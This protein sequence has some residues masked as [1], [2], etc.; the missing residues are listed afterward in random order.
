MESATN[1]KTLIDQFELMAR[2]NAVSSAPGSQSVS[3]FKKTTQLKADNLLVK[4][5][6][7]HMITNYSRTP[8]KP[9]QMIQ[10]AE[11][12]VEPVEDL[13]REK[14]EVLCNTSRKASFYKRLTVHTS[15]KYD[16]TALD[17]YDSTFC[18]KVPRSPSYSTASTC[19]LDSLLSPQDSILHELLQKPGETNTEV[20][21]R[22]RRPARDENLQ[23]TTTSKWIPA[24]S[25]RRSLLVRKPPF[26]TKKE[27][28]IPVPKSTSLSSKSTRSAVV[29]SRPVKSLS[30]ISSSPR[31]M[32]YASSPRY[33][34]TKAWNIE[35]RRQLE[36]RNRSLAIDKA[37][38]P[39]AKQHTRHTRRSSRVE[40]NKCGHDCT[41]SRR[42]STQQN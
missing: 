21:S 35:R 27:S 22:S 40:R 3:T 29:S 31:Y 26:M 39:I 25:N 30:N 33:S 41:I 7:Q 32:N 2:A 13:S 23:L 37:M 11:K 16:T 18:S 15:A 38:L 6:I 20:V 4:K 8:S 36:E 12:A 10:N 1:V 24:T 19:S 17:S 14:E 5:N 42:T 28:S 9:V 34:A